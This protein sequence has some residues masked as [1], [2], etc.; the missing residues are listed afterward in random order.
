VGLSFDLCQEAFLEKMDSTPES[1]LINFGAF[2]VVCLNLSPAP[3]FRKAWSSRSTKGISATFLLSCNACGL[4]W[5]LYALKLGNLPMVCT[6]IPPYLISLFFAC[7]YFSIEKRLASFLFKYL[8]AALISS[9]IVIEWLTLSHAGTLA[10]ICNLA[11]IVSQVEYIGHALAEKNAEGIDLNILAASMLCSL[12][13]CAYGWLTNDIYVLIPNVAGV[14]VAC[15]QIVV[16][17]W[18]KEVIPHGVLAPLANWRGYK[19]S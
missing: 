17:L 13:W 15:V 7:V 3:A 16:Y 12:D 1:F 6:N 11:I 4:A 19:R 18:A 14:Y 2:L 5:L 9:A 10:V 8:T